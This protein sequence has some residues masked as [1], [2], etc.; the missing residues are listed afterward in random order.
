MFKV[1]QIDQPP[2][3]E[4]DPFVPY[5]DVDGDVW[6]MYDTED[7]DTHAYL[8]VCLTRNLTM[9]KDHQTTKPVLT[10]Y[11]EQ[12]GPFHLFHGTLVVGDMDE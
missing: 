11:L 5:I 8:W 9:D 10:P 2:V 1:Q 7:E 6:V 3:T 12:F 4:F